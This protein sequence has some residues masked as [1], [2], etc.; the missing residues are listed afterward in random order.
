MKI[1]YGLLLATLLFPVMLNATEK[2]LRPSD[3]L[4]SPANYLNREVEIDV[5]EPLYGP[6]SPVALAAAQYGQVEIMIPDAHGA[7]L[8]MVSASWKAGDPNRYRHKFDQVLVSP[9]KVRGQFLIDEE[10]SQQYKKPR[11]VLRVSGFEPLALPAPQTLRSIAELKANP[12]H[13]DRKMVTYEGVFVQ[14]FEVSSLDKEIWLSFRPKTE[15][16]NQQPA[17][18]GK[19]GASYRVR[20]TGILFAK[21]G[22]RYGHLGG[23][24]YELVASKVEF[25]GL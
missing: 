17:T 9:L 19:G 3:L 1:R 2:A 5:V 8:D 25:L 10:L 6:S 7:E 13:W 24:P 18:P 20:V 4:A 21:P 23:Y 14:S 22:A 15:F 11:Y 16:L 12:A